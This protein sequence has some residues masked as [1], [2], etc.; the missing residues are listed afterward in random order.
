MDK[1]HGG[2]QE[3][4]LMPELTN[5]AESHVNFSNNEKFG[6]AY[7]APNTQ[8]TIAGMV[9]QT[10]GIPLKMPM[11][12]NTYI[13]YKKFL[14]GV[15]TLGD[16]LK[17]NGYN[18]MLMVG[19]DSRFAGRDVYFKTHGNYVIK[20]LY[21][22]R[23]EKIVDKDHYVFWGYEDSYL[24]K[25]AKKE[26]KKLSEKDKPFNFTMLTVSTHFPN[27]YVE[28]SCKKIFDDKYSNAVACSSK[29][30]YEFVNWIKEQ[31]FYEDTTIVLVGDHISMAENKMFNDEDYSRTIFN[32]FINSAER[33]RNNKN[34]SFTSFDLFP[35]TLASIGATI[36]GNKLGLGVNLYSDKKTLIEKYDIDYVYNEIQKKSTFYN[37]KF[38]YNES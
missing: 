16:I 38:L 3:V 31:D 22:A 28:K 7:Q 26:I 11:D 20:D 37:K 27:G 29:Q 6:G 5:L 4:N 21:T 23:K 30:L 17:E 33:E 2:N 15:Y 24:Y 12:S 36:E 25:Y 32:I 1:E 14:P 18:Q 34:R 10:S 8:W 9:S 19:S 35:T 13:G